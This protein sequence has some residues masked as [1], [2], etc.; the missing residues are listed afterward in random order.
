MN[1]KL[2]D[3]TV[4]K[5][6]TNVFLDYIDRHKY[7]MDYSPNQT[8][9]FEG[10]KIDGVYVINDGIAKMVVK[11]HRGRPLIIRL[12]KKGEI[13][14]HSA[15]NKSRQPATITAVEPVSVC[16]WEKADFEKCIHSSKEIRNEVMATLK[17]EVK[18]MSDRSMRL[19][20]MSVREKVADALL[21]IADAYQIKD[22]GLLHRIALSR[23]EISEMIGTSKA[24][25]SKILQEFKAEGLLDI[26]PKTLAF[27]SFA[28]LRAIAG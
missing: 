10:A 11:G 22:D 23:Q 24:Q 18:N 20:Q 15:D 16:F 13:I 5:N 14:G 1:C 25:T 7:C 12:L 2:K 26:R 28:K 19:V 8:I 3:C 17:Q 6:S 27:F 21:M 9:I 4:L